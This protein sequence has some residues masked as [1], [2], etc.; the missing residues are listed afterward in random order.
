MYVHPGFCCTFSSCWPSATRV[1]ITRPKNESKEDKKLRKQAVKAERQERRAEKKA[2][3]E[4]FSS[5]IKQEERVVVAK[6]KTTKM[7]K[8]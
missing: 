8:L 2:N 6:E 3:K 5:A 7:R 1:T 4:Q